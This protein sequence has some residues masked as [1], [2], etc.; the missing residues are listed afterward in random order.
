MKQ[1][2]ELNLHSNPS[3]F[4][5]R[6]RRILDI[7]AW[8]KHKENESE[9]RSQKQKDKKEQKHYYVNRY[10][11][12]LAPPQEMDYPATIKYFESQGCVRNPKIIIIG[13]TI[14]ERGVFRMEVPQGT[15]ATYAGKKDNDVAGRFGIIATD[16]NGVEVDDN[17]KIEI[18][19][20]DKS[21]KDTISIEKAY[22]EV[23]LNKSRAS[24]YI[25]YP[26]M[27]LKPAIRKDI[28]EFFKFDEGAIL[29]YP[30]QQIWEVTSDKAVSIEYYGTWDF[31]VS[32]PR[33]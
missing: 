4:L 22:A 9:S 21:T 15:W 31:W 7:R 2:N 33:G 12:Q 10:G 13:A 16:E 18:K 11:K 8:K 32:E 6:I 17:T 14:D 24:F 27:V 28:S 30:Q 29:K 1:G 26:K 25:P 20:Y 23:S 19:L 3:F 5:G